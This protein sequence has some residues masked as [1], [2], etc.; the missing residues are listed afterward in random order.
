VIIGSIEIRPEL[1]FAILAILLGI[2]NLL[3]WL[4]IVKGEKRETG[5]QSV[6]IE[7]IKS[8][9]SQ[10]EERLVNLLSRIKSTPPDLRPVI[11]ILEEIKESKLEVGELNIEPI[12]E[13]LKKELKN[14][15][16]LYEALDAHIVEL[17]NILKK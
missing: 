2:I 5:I 8:E 7:E 3:L 10:T 17:I 4:F 16:K 1:V 13:E 11:E 12:K 9:L 6:D 15:E 14:I